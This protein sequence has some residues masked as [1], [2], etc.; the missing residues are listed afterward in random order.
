MWRPAP[1]HRPLVSRL[2]QRLFRDRRSQHEPR[3]V[4]TTGRG[5]AEANP[6]LIVMRDSVGLLNI[7][8]EGWTSVENVRR[9]DMKAWREEKAS[10]LGRD[11]RVLPIQRDAQRSR[12]RTVRETLGALTP[13]STPAPEDCHEMALKG[14]RH[15]KH[16]ACSGCM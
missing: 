7:V 14:M 1:S 11:G 13:V 16:I 9:T 8:G 6:A 15:K 5:R 3:E 12:F 10:G 2:R 4:W